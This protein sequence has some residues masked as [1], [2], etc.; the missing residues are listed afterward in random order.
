MGRGDGV[1]PTSTRRTPTRWSASTPAPRRPTRAADRGGEG[2]VPGVVAL[3]HPAAPRDPE[4]GRRTRSSP[5]RTNSAGCCRA[6]RARR[7]AEGDR[8]DGARRP[9]LRVLRRRGAAHGGRA[10][11]LGAPGRRRRGHARAGRRRRHHHAVE[12]PDRHPRLEDRA[13]ARL[14]QHGGVQAR[15]PGARLSLGARRHPEAAPGC[16]RAC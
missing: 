2:G 14:R 7:C 16:P 9:D 3:R 13:G 10:R 1:T 11:A 4:E 5:A 15:R 6:K 12:F 8:R